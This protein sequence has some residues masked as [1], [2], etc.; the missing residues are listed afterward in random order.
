L[1]GAKKNLSNFIHSRERRR[2]NSLTLTAG[3]APFGHGGAAPAGVNNP[4][5]WAFIGHRAGR[6]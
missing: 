6:A 2:Q 5:H 3:V 1:A 4:F